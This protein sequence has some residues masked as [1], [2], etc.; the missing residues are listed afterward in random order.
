MTYTFDFGSLTPRQR[1][2]VTLHYFNGWTMAEIAEALRVHVRG[3][4]SCNT[5]ALHVLKA[6]SGTLTRAGL[7]TY[8]NRGSL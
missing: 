3:V 6:D 2:V 5:R 1:L 8:R 7:C 4:Q